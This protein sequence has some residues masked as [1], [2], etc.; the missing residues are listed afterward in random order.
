MENL[1]KI[2]LVFIVVYGH[3]RILRDAKIKRPI[4]SSKVVYSQEVSSVNLAHKPDKGV[5]Y[6]LEGKFVCYIKL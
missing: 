5:P 4:R 6:Y 2:L 3:Y 1:E